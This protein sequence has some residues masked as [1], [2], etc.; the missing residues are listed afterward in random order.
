[1]T[2]RGI[3]SSLISCVLSL[4]VGLSGAGCGSLGVARVVGVSTFKYFF[5]VLACDLVGAIYFFPFAPILSFEGSDKLVRLC[6]CFLGDGGMS[7][8]RVVSRQLTFLDAFL[9]GLPMDG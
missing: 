6:T 2:L 5:T 8:L 9:T 7:L 4:L 3:S 1:M